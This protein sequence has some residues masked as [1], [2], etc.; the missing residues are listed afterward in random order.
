MTMATFIIG[1]V[2]IIQTL[3]SD[4]KHL[5]NRFNRFETDITEEV[6][7]LRKV[8]LELARYQGKTSSLEQFIFQVNTRLDSFIQGQLVDAKGTP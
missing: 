3:K 1:S 5:S 6:S 2:I 8:M 4:V 7:E